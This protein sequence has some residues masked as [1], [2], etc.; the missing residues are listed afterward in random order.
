MIIYNLFPSLTGNVRDW[1]PHLIRA[2]EMG[3]DW[4]FINPIQYPG[5]SGSL[6]SIK[7]YFRLNP[8]FVDGASSTESVAEFK[9][10]A[11][12]AQA[13]GRK[14]MVDLVVSHCAFDSDLI[15]EHPGWFRK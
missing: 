8:L 5:Y 13:L 2:A 9:R 7:D 4:V 1:K 12:D 15:T 11:Q 10:M 6:Y 3:F 14:L